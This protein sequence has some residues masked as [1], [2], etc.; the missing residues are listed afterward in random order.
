MR[1]TLLMI[2]ACLLIGCATQPNKLENECV[3][4]PEKTIFTFWSSVAEKMEVRLYD[5]YDA[6]EF[7]VITLQEKEGDY[8]TATIKGD[9][10]GKFY[11]VCSYQNGE[12][13][14]ESPGI[15]AK[16]V[17]V[18]GQRAAIIDMQ[19]TN[20][21]GWENDQRPAMTDPTDVV[22]YETHMRDFTI[23]ATSGI[24][25]KGKFIAFTEQ[26]TQ[27]AEG[28]ASGIDHLKELG[29][30]HIQ[31]LPMYDYGSIDETTLD[32]N[33]YNWGYD[34]V[35]YNV[36][37]GG[38]STNPYDPATRIREAK[39]M[40]QAL[41]AAGIR[42]IMDVVY[43]HT[44]S[45]EGCALGRVV[46]QYFYRMNEDGTYANG[47]GCDNE[48]A[49]DKEMMRQFMVESV[50]YWAREYHIDGFRFDLM[51][52]HDQETMRQIRAALDEIDP[53]II[54]YGEGW[55]ASSPA[56]P[57]EQLAMK[58]W[59]Y[60]MPRVGAFSD[61]IRNALIGSPFDHHRG[62]ASGNTASRDAVR[63]GLVACPD[64][65]GEPMQH[66]SYITCHDNY[67][68]RDRIEV[69]A[70]EE[71]EATKLRMNKLAQTAV[72]VSQGM[73]FFYGGEEL[74]RTKQGV[75]N[76]YQSPDSINVIE[77]ANKQTYN[78]LYTYYRE[79]IKIRRQH[80]G[81]RLGTAELVKNHVEF[82]ETTQEGL[83]IYRIKDLQGIDTASSL[84]VLLNGT[85]EAIEA[86]VP[87]ATYIVLAQ[88]AQANANGMGTI[89]G[90]KVQVAPYSATI[91]AQ[92]N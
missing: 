26:G 30:T 64:W 66:V 52:I 44:Y 78:D 47:S 90:G 58:Q 80:K 88:D 81:F 14:Q 75:E 12:W 16:A 85:A 9:Q 73:T 1:N 35:N 92:I 68:L 27:T 65:S 10:V 60:T 28:L 24:A 34:P 61:D 29:I 2:L 36:P 48:T 56:Y 38:Y 89:E 23:D 42:V 53:S 84:V 19:A 70:A 17:S 55:A 20:P 45:V 59:T 13:G 39:T 8:W 32:L 5:T 6:S 62:F 82:P 91:L 4:T 87:Q 67:C 22:V 18:N 25:N 11:T 83:I 37:E 86:E 21:E 50:C 54:T 63:Y 72:M 79:I 77:W 71:T 40:I 15:F 7:E 69:A 57:Y 51:G 31:I 76:S 3:Y 74:F 43:N 46:P 33:K 49:S 41:H